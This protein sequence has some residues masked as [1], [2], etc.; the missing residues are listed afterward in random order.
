M[1]TEVKLT[2]TEEEIL[3]IAGGYHGDPFGI[4]GPHEFEKGIVVRAF[5]PQATAVTVI[6]RD[7]GKPVPMAR[8]HEMGFFQASLQNYSLPFP[9]QFSITTHVG[10]SLLHED[11]YAY[12]SL[13]SDFDK[14]LLAEGTHLHSYEQ[15]GAHIRVATAKL[16]SFLQYGRLEPF[17]YPLSASSTSGTAVVIL[18]VSILAPAFGK[19]LSLVWDKA[20][21]TNTKSKPNIRNIWSK[22][23]IQLV[24]SAKCVLKLPQSSGI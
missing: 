16:V 7:G 3:A 1:A 10:E 18:C 15:L 24:F 8:V 21:C 14:Y 19:S 4:L 5:L 11:P 13:L 17:G 23:P 22:R 6:P 2:V 12:P 9:Y 20:H